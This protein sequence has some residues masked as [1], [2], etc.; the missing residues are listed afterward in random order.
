MKGFSQKETLAEDGFLSGFHADI[1]SCLYTISS[2]MI[3]P[4]AV[5]VP[6]SANG[7]HDHRGRF[8]NPERIGEE[9]PA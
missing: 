3:K 4:R 7:L 6:F 2:R 1:W 9:K 5:K 8:F